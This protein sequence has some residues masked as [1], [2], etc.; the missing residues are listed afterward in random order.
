MDSWSESVSQKG[1]LLHH[2]DKLPVTIGLDTEENKKWNTWK[3]S[4][5][6]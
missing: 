1:D 3:Y 6:Q 4:G 5:Q 2:W